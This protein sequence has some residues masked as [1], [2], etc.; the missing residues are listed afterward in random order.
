LWYQAVALPEIVQTAVVG[1]T[2]RSAVLCFTG[3]LTSTISGA[4]PALAE[5]SKIHKQA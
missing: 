3:R 1:I 5:N 4:G 2:A